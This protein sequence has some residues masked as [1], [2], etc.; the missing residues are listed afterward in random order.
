MLVMLR[1]QVIDKTV[2]ITTHHYRCCVLNCYQQLSSSRPIREGCALKLICQ[3]A[4]Y[5]K[6][7][8]ASTC[9]CFL[10]VL[11]NELLIL[12][13]TLHYN[14]VKLFP[15]FSKYYC[16]MDPRSQLKA[17]LCLIRKLWRIG[18]PF[19]PRWRFSGMRCLDKHLAWKLGTLT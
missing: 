11:V 4:S 17:L 5:Q 8:N 16:R 12:R 3:L 6:A 9:Q 14:I 13:L 15:L 2:S 19:E 18:T 1:C 7:Y 10:L